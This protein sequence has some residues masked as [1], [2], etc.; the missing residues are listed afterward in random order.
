[1]GLLHSPTD[2]ASGRQPGLFLV[3]LGGRSE[4]CLIEQHDGRLVVGT[5]LE[6]TIPELRRQWRGLRRGL[7]IDGP[8]R[9]SP[10]ASGAGPPA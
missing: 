6:A 1:M 7:R 2:N 8:A 4:G 9:F 5:C 10:P 3:V